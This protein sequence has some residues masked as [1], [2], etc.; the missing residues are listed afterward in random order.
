MQLAENVVFGSKRK[1]YF[2]LQ[3]FGRLKWSYKNSLFWSCCLKIV[4][5]SVCA[6]M[7]MC[8]YV[9]AYRGRRSVLDV[10]LYHSTVAFWNKVSQWTW[11]S[12]P[13]SARDPLIFTPLALGLKLCITTPGPLP[14]AWKSKVRFS[15]LHG[16]HFANWIIFPDSKLLTFDIILLSTF[17]LWLRQI[18]I[19]GV[20]KYGLVISAKVLWKL[21]RTL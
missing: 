8:V 17:K 4:S 2:H 13:G 5:C 18:C 7:G 6:H 14:K 12:S 19:A 3:D 10:F 16:K 20:V 1:W 21:E 9:C 15:C 11:S